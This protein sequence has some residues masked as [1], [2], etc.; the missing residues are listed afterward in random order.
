MLAFFVGFKCVLGKISMEHIDSKD[1]L[2][3][4]LYF[5]SIC[6]DRILANFREKCSKPGVNLLTLD[7]VELVPRVHC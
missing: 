4:Q 6:S 2:N 3:Y 7:G 1:S 5:E